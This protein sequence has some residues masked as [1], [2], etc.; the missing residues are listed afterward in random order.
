MARCFGPAILLALVACDA[1]RPDEPGGESATARIAWHLPDVRG[2]LLSW[3][4]ATYSVNVYAYASGASIAAVQ[5]ADRQ[6]VWGAAGDESGATEFNLRGI[7]VCGETAVFG[8]DRAVYGVNR[9]G[10]Q[11]RWRWGAINAL[12]H[13][14]PR[15]ADGAVYLAACVVPIIVALG[16]ATGVERWRSDVRRDTSTV[17][18]TIVGFATTPSV[19]GGVVVTCTREVGF[20]WRGQVVALDAASG[21]VRWRY[22]WEPVG[23]IVHASCPVAMVVVDGLAIA[24]VDDGRLIAL[25]LETGAVR[26]TAPAV[27]D[28]LTQ[29]EER[30]LAVT[31]GIVAAG[32]LSGVVTGYDVATGTTRW[33]Y[34]T[35]AD[36]ATTVTDRGLL[37]D[38]GQFIGTTMSGRLYALDARTGAFQ[39]TIPPGDV[40]VRGFLPP[41]TATADLFLAAA[42][43]GL[44]AVRRR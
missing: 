44:Y 30:P 36:A 14:S 4:I 15:C 35:R 5:L 3:W 17:P 12:E 39:W 34:G 40:N 1:Q 43:D 20:P 6:R 27:P 23:R 41:G 32:S 9:N 26:W 8:S 42:T 16:A 28:F 11:R 13:G 33:T 7:A 10:G 31:S 29:W 19:G 25:D 18:T 24:S 21:R 2:P 22:Q 38:A 37:G